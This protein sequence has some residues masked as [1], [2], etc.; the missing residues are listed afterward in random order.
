MID[1]ATFRCADPMWELVYHAYHVRQR[2]SSVEQWAVDY[3][4][5]DDDERARLRCQL[6]RLHAHRYIQTLR[7]M[8][9]DDGDW[10]EDKIKEHEGW[11]HEDDQW[12]RD[13]KL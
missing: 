13:G 11:L 9:W 10:W 6:V 2:I 7:R 1:W 3:R 8:P 4:I 12:Y 5:L